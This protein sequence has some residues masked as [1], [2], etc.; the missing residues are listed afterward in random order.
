MR[1]E[2]E[3]NRSDPLNPTHTHPNSI[4]RLP[5][6]ATRDPDNDTEELRR[7]RAEVAR[8]EAA[9]AAAAASASSTST[10]G[11]RAKVTAMSAEVRGEDGVGPTLGM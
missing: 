7:L 11:G 4:D 3:S 10:G 1:N 2:I 8:L 9:L 5:N 6:M